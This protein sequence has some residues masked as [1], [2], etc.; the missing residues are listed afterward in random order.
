[1][2]DLLYLLLSV[3]LDFYLFVY[4]TVVV[5]LFL[6]DFLAT[7]LIEEPMKVLQKTWQRIA[8]V[9]AVGGVLGVGSLL[10]VPEP[11]TDQPLRKVVIFIVIPGLT[12]LVLSMSKWIKARKGIEPFGFENFFYGYLYGLAYVLVRFLFLR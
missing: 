9:V 10:A 3:F 12:G 11:V 6:F 4:W 8:F 1:M 7:L 5:A 2:W